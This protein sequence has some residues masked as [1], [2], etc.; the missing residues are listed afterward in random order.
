[1]YE[2]YDVDLYHVELRLQVRIQKW[3]PRAEPGIVNQVIYGQRGA[4]GLAV[5]FGGPTGRERSAG[6]TFAETLKVVCISFAIWLS[7]V[8][9]RATSTKFAP[10]AAKHLASSYPMPDDAPVINAVLPMGKWYNS[11]NGL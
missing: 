2:R 9:S 11:G 8:T 5:N 3:A 1:V 6:M 4:L 7:V 10:P